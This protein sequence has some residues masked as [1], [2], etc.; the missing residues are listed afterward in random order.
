M[1]QMEEHAL[2]SD[3]MIALDG[4]TGTSTDTQKCMYC[5]V[6]THAQAIILKGSTEA[7]STVQKL[8]TD[9]RL[10]I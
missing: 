2:T 5:A 8:H 10:Y 3:S 4:T 6:H 9:I 7:F 1:V